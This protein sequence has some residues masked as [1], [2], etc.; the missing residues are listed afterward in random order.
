MLAIRK[1]RLVVGLA[2]CCG[3]FVLNSMAWTQSCNRS[4]P[5]LSFGSFDVT[6]NTPSNGSTTISV[7]CTALY[8]W[9][10]AYAST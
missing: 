3:E 2:I 6:A 8:L 7:R 5:D 4:I 9:R 1:I 10:C